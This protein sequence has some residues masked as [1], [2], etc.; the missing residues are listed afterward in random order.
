MCVLFVCLMCMTWFLWRF[1]RSQEEE[2]DEEKIFSHG[3]GCCCCN[4]RYNLRF[5]R[6]VSCGAIGGWSVVERPMLILFVCLID[7]LICALQDV[8]VIWSLDCLKSSTSRIYGLNNLAHVCNGS[9]G[10]CEQQLDSWVAQKFLRV[11]A[12]AIGVVNRYPEL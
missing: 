12:A 8:I 2:E 6:K 10:G 7:G 3:G 1:E 9:G 5:F 4:L 11:G